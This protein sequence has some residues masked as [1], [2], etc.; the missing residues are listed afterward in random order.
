[1]T[2]EVEVAVVAVVVVA[3]EEIVMHLEAVAEEIARPF[4]KTER[5]VPVH[6]RKRRSR[7]L[8]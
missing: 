2:V 8:T 6:L 3:V 4:S 7:L 5:R 1:M